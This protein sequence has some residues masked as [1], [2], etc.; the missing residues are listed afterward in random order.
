MLLALMV[1]CSLTSTL[2]DLSSG[3]AVPGACGEGQTVCG[4]KCVDT[5]GKNTGQR[6][7]LT[8]GKRVLRG[9]AVNGVLPIANT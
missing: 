1:S 9:C 6:A 4:G 3:E 5:A 2:D 7:T 8:L